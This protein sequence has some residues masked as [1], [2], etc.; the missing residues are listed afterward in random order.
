MAGSFVCRLNCPSTLPIVLQHR[1]KHTQQDCISLE[2][3]EMDENHDIT[4]I[5]KVL[6]DWI[7]RPKTESL[8]LHHLLIDEHRQ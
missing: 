7:A 8:E 6:H 3:E 2:S 1:Q 4:G 5:V